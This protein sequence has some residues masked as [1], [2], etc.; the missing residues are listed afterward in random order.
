MWLLLYK[1]VEGRVQKLLYVENCICRLQAMRFNFKRLVITFI[2]I[3][4]LFE[5]FQLKVDKSI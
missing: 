3:I 2:K 1:H 4:K 5:S